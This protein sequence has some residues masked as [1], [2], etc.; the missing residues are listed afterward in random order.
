MKKKISLGILG[1]ITGFYF[2]IKPRRK[3]NEAMQKFFR[4]PY[5]HRGLHGEVHPENT[6][7]ALLAAVERGYAIE[8]D[9]RASRDGLVIHHDETLMRSSGL[10]LIIEELDTALLGTIPLFGSQ[11]T[12][13][14][15]KEALEII[16]GRVPLLLEIKSETGHFLHAKQVQQVMDQYPGAYLIESFQPLVLLWYRLY[17][18]KVL[19][20]QL[21]GNNL[22][23]SF[24]VDKAM[25][26]YLFNS[27]SRPD[28][29]AFDKKGGFAPWLL[30]HLGTP[31]FVYTLKAPGEK[32]DYFRGEIFEDYLP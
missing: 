3:N 14:T 21:S 24:L 28:F 6:R 4:V 20:G 9:V 16:G 23:K 1:L 10:S 19:R 13:P 17:R 5:A 27:I 8:M 25:A 18:P 15:L 30:H 2:L 31:S 32:K 11:E 7:G 29:I 26:L 12:I 22:G